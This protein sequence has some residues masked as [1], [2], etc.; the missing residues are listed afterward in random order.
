MVLGLTWARLGFALLRLWIGPLSSVRRI[1]RVRG[2][3]M[4]HRRESARAEIRDLMAWNP[5]L[6]D[7]ALLE[8]G[9]T[10]QDRYRLSY[11]GAL[12]VAAAMASACAHLLP[13]DF[14][15]GQRLDG[16]EVLNPFCATRRRSRLF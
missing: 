4:A 5:V 14:Q 9:W 3:E 2:A 15:T 6:A 10:I 16:I 7:A 1:L 11:W 12:I 8:R 13:E